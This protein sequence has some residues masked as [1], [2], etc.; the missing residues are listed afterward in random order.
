MVNYLNLLLL[1]KRNRIILYKI[2]LPH[3]NIYI[4]L[5]KPV[6]LFVSFA[7]SA[8]IACAI[9]SSDA[10]D[11][12]VECVQSYIHVW[13]SIKRWARGLLAEE[14]SDRETLSRQYF[15]GEFFLSTKIPR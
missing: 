11:N 8:A 5:V 3:Y 14:A 15:L 10:I 6:L 2:F 12:T 7:A 13:A 4:Q 1:R 9:I